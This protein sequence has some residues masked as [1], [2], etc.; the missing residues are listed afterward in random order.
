MSLRSDCT[1]DPRMG[2]R[3]EVRRRVVVLLVGQVHGSE[4]PSRLILEAGQI[5]LK[6]S[7]KARSRSRWADLCW[8]TVTRDSGTDPL[9]TASVRFGPQ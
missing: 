9:R 2:R 6:K 1:R 4:D 3:T 8:L 7:D 5:E